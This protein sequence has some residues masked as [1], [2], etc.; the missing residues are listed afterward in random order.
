MVLPFLMLFLPITK[1]IATKGSSCEDGNALNIIHCDD[2]I[3]SDLLLHY[4]FL[5]TCTTDVEASVG[6]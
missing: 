3:N 6:Y 2:L 1:V 4:Y 5:S